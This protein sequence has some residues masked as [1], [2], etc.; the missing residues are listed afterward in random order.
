[1]LIGK[2]KKQI[3]MEQ[4]PTAKVRDYAG[5]DA[6]AALHLAEIF[7]PQLEPAGLRKPS[8]QLEVPLLDVPAEMELTGIRHAV[9]FLE[10]RGAEMAAE[11]AGVE[12]EIYALAGHEFN[13]GSLKQLQT[14]LFTELKL[15][16]QKKTG[17]KGEPSTDQESLERLA[18]LGHDLPRKLVA[19]R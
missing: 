2:G 15:P 14:V 12:K 7:E 3:T 16:V 1:D 8:A 17:I 10:K 4:V 13:I 11:L 9:P 6:D 18:A 19:Y 5:E